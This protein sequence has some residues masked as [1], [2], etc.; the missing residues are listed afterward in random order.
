MIKSISVA[1]LFVALVTGCS[2]P[3]QKLSGETG[4][5]SA[6]ESWYRSR[7]GTTYYVNKGAK[8]EIFDQYGSRASVTGKFKVSSFVWVKGLPFYGVEVDG[9]KNG[10]MRADTFQESDLSTES[11]WER[12]RRLE[13]EREKVEKEKADA[14]KK[15]VSEAIAALQSE[16]EAELKA[17]KLQPGTVLY[18]RGPNY[19]DPGLTKVTV[20]GFKIEAVQKLKDLR[21]ATVYLTFDMPD[22]KSRQLALFTLALKPRNARE[23]AGKDFYFTLPAWGAARMKDIRNERISMG[24]TE[25]QVLASWGYPRKMNNSTGRWGTHQQWVYGD[26]GPYVYFENGRLTS[27]QN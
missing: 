18:L 3:S 23:I 6:Q 10:V 4:E 26:F 16:I 8:P 14:E 17:A 15:A 22:R 25:D 9:Y 19:G 20:T 21:F 2:S 5:A 24:M 11:P 27:W 12:S 7:V 1:L 13:V